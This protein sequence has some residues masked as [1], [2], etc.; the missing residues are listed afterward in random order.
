MGE[1]KEQIM[2]DF[3]KE[4][5]ILTIRNGFWIILAVLVSLLFYGVFQTNTLEEKHDSLVNVTNKINIMANTGKKYKKDVVIDKEFF[6]KNDIIFEKMAKKYEYGKYDNFDLS[7]ASEEEKKKY[8]EYYLKNGEYLQN[9]TSYNY[10]SKEMKEKTNNFFSIPISIT[11]MIVVLVLGFLFSSMEHS[12]SYY[13]F[14][15]TYPWTKKKDFLMKII[16]G[17][18]IIF[19]FVLISSILNYMIVKTSNFEILKTGVKYIPGNLKNFGFLSALYLTILSVGFM[20]GNILGHVGLGVMT[21]FFIDIVN[22]IW[23]SLNMLFKGEFLYERSLIY[24]IEDKIPNDESYF[25]KIIKVILRPASNYDN[26]YL[27]LAGLIIFSFFVFIISYSLIEK[28]KTEKSG[29]MVLLKPIENLAKVLII[30]L[31]ACVG[32]MIFQQS[33]FKGFS[34]INFVIFAILI[35]VFTKIF[36]ILFKLKLKV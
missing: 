9:L 30:L 29:K 6:E 17:F 21:F 36:N 1:G 20:A 34:I 16:F 33:V 31:C 19:G 14:A 35:F 18:M 25:N 22:S 15:R 32:I 23:E 24:L 7:K 28:T 4:I 12:T 13:E 5:K 26:S 3:K 2:K 10:L 27:A 8:D 11:G